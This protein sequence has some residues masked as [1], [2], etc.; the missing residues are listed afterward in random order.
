[1]A[2]KRRLVALGAVLSGCVAVATPALAGRGRSDRTDAQNRHAAARDASQLLRRV[3]LPAGAMPSSREPGGDG[4]VLGSPP[5]SEG[6]Q[7]LIDR[8]G[9]WTVNEPPDQVLGYITSHPPY[10]GVKNTT[11]SGG[12]N[13]PSWSCVGFGFP[14]RAGVLGFRELTVKVVGLGNG[15]SGIRTDA[16]VQWIIVRPAGERVPPGVGEIVV[17]RSGQHGGE[18]VA[19]G[20]PST[21][22]KIIRLFDALPVLQP[23]AWSC[24]AVPSKAALDS[25]SFQPAGGGRALARASVRAD[26]GRSNTGCDAMSFSIGGRRQLPLVRARRF[27]LAVGH[28]LQFRLT[29]RPT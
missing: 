3:K 10:G 17:A 29:Q 2:G 4:G 23:G 25:F 26:V 5:F 16:Q 7:N 28:L 19:V 27:L 13:Q 9:W 12:G 22:H 6:V 18:A 14:A 1:M 11:C 15:R 24:P 21:M 20:D 8:H